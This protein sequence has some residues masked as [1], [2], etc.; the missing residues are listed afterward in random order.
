[1]SR[2]LEMIGPDQ[3]YDRNVKAGY[4]DDLEQRKIVE[5]FADLHQE[6]LRRHS[7]PSL[8]SRIKRG[9]SSGSRD[10]IKGLYLWGGVGSGKTYLMDL[11]PNR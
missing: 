1:M 10:P 9:L 8:L 4:V 11:F 6:V 5:I 3:R 2:K 7:S